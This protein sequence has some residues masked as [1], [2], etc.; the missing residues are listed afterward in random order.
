[1]IYEIKYM[2][3]AADDIAELKKSDTK[4]YTKLLSLLRELH[5]HPRTGTGKPE[6]M[7]YGSLRGLWSRRIN[8]KHRLVYEIRDK[9]VL[10]LVLSA[11]GHYED[12]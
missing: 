3:E 9:E 7:K 12:K 8:Q 4:S 10:V 2:P 1:M 11:K 6:Y 5:E